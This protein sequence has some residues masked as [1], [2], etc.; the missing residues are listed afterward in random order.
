MVG[1]WAP[2]RGQDH[3]AQNAVRAAPSQPGRG[4]WCSA[5]GRPGASRPTC[6][7]ISLVMG[8][9]SYALVVC[10]HE[11]CSCTRSM[12][13]LDRL[14][15]CHAGRS[16]SWPHIAGGCTHLCTS[17]PQALLGERIVRWKRC[18][19][20]SSIAPDVPVSWT[21]PSHRPWTSSISSVRARVPA[22]PQ[23]RPGTTD[24]PD[25]PLN[26]RH[27]GVCPRVRSSHHGRLHFDGPA[28][29]PGEASRASQAHQRHLREPVARRRSSGPERP[30][31][32]P[33]GDGVH[34]R[35]APP[36]SQVAD[37]AGRPAAPGRGPI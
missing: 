35:L 16:T 31:L 28:G 2:R 3:H 21:S 32:E 23:P 14:P 19:S 12:Y 34:L 18:S 27:P 6:R 8:Q 36:R 10:G 29:R 25:Q 17:S 37:V 26:G 7:R 13:G 33:S 15:H 24:P 11:P 30:P 20:R 9:K 22:L 5:D 4:R 1:F